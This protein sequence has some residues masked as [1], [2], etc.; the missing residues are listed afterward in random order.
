MLIIIT[1]IQ[2]LILRSNILILHYLKRP[3]TY[4]NLALIFVRHDLNTKLL[5]VLMN[6]LWFFSNVLLYTHQGD[7]TC[8]KKLAIYLRVSLK[9]I[10]E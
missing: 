1:W 9:L 10:D 4:F 7:Q 3:H 5:A 8:F 2:K 6:F